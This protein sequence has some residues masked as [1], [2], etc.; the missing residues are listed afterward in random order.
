MIRAR[1]PLT[2]AWGLGLALATALISGV[3]IWLNAFAVKQVPDA[4]L[5]TTLKNL[6]AAVILVSAAVGTGG[7]AEA[8]RLD[9]RAWSRLLVIGVIGGSVPF[10]LFF[11]GLAQ[12]TAPGAAFIHK[13]LF[14]WVA[15][16]AVPLLGE[17]LGMTQV[18]ALAVLIVGQLLLAPPR[19]DGAGWSTGETMILAATLLWAV[20]VVVA[21]RLLGSVSPG[22][23]GA[24]RLGFGVILLVGFLAATGGLA[25]ITGLTAEAWVWVLV[26]GMVLS[27]YVGTWLA[28][29]RRAPASAVTSVLVLGA[30]VTA[31]LQALAG[32]TPPSPQALLGIGALV[33]A[34]IV[35][36]RS[37][38][39][40]AAAAAPP[41]PAVEPVVG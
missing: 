9:R 23:V 8:R 18:V 3:A 33:L 29:L 10:L 40:A 25:G 39:R 32:G 15:L 41:A 13:T 28:A 20:E 21:K 2:P 7:A 26:T 16:L 17:R 4:A 37:A 6:V 31:G 1:I 19:I 11:G 12:A 24:A 35:V 22:I 14:V 30:V 34:A 5:Y 27:A 36:V 38:L